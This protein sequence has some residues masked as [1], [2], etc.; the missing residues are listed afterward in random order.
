MASDHEVLII[1][2]GPAGL[3]AAMALGRLSRRALLCDDGRPRNAASAHMNNFPSRDG[4]DPK[5]W[6]RQV[7]QELEKYKTVQFR[8]S[9]VL[10]VTRDGNL[11]RATFPE[12]ESL[13]FRKV[14]LAYGIVDRLP[15]LTGLR[16]LWGKSVFH[17]PYCHGFEVRDTPLGLVAN[18]VFAEHLLPMIASL[19][20]D[21]VLLTNGPANISAEIRGHAER[22][23][24]R[25]IESPV[26]SL[27]H[28]G[29]RLKSVVFEDGTS[30]ERDALF[31]A[32]Q[33]PFQA[34][35]SIGEQL[36]C[37]KTEMGFYQV[38]PFGKTTVGGVFAAGDI[39]TGN[40]S[41][42]GAAA[43]GQLAGAGIVSELLN[44]IFAGGPNDIRA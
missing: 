31:W 5:D 28:M 34:K 20:P 25:L 4:I 42:L 19:S 6:R 3:G 41:V 26:A 1:G 10:S 13:T 24:V 32:P 16:E 7:R 12:G 15:P 23:R 21:T 2:A 17:C 14:L 18:G 36:G 8:Q 9:S 39:M 37:E 11:F 33:L 35:S 38:N 29:E 43:A 44:E 30:L 22:N 40:H 27:K